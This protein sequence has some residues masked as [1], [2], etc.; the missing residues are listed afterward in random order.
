M[1]QREIYKLVERL[2]SYQFENELDLLCALVRYFVGREELNIIGGRVWELDSS[3]DVYSL[4]YQ[5]GEVDVIPD[6]YSIKISEQPVFDQLSARRT[7]INYETDTLLLE[8]GIHL[9]SATGV[10]EMVKRASGKF[11]SYALAFNGVHLNQEFFDI[12]SVIGSA[13][14][15]AMPNRK[16]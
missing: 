9:Y 13:A 6:D 2:F 4:R 11:Y 16:N 3:E 12:L 14:T 7:V 8:K 5:F 1:T 15:T 10:G